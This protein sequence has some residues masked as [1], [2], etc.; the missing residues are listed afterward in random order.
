MAQRE[1]DVQRHQGLKRM[2]S[3]INEGLGEIAHDLRAPDIDQGLRALAS[4][5]IETILRRYFIQIVDDALTERA[6][7]TDIEEQSIQGIRRSRRMQIKLEAGVFEF[8]AAESLA[9]LKRCVSA[10]PFR[11]ERLHGQAETGAGEN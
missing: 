8:E 4:A 5:C 11:E 3:G 9:G 7:M 1:D 6:V 2:R 10:F